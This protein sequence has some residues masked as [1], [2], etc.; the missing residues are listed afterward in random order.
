[1]VTMHSL[2]VLVKINLVGEVFYWC[3][4]FGEVWLQR[5]VNELS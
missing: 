3:Q 2:V 4:I 5:L 1:M